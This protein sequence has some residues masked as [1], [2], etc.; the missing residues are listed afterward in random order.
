MLSIPHVSYRSRV[1]GQINSTSIKGGGGHG[2][3]EMTV[4]KRLILFSISSL[5]W[6]ICIIYYVS[7]FK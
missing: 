3:E 4:P 1:G 7:S 5:K 6:N 2:A